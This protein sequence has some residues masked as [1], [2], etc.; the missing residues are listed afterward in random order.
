VSR[1]AVHIVNTTRIDNVFPQCRNECIAG[2]ETGH[3]PDLAR[4]SELEVVEMRS[5]IRR[6]LAVL[7]VPVLA[8][9]GVTMVWTGVASAHHVD[10]INVSCDY[11]TVNFK[12]FPSAGVNVHIAAAIEGHGDLA[13]DVL[14]HDEMSAQLDITSATSALAGA[15]AEVDVDVTWTFEG[16]QHV[17]DTFTVTCGSATTTTV[18]HCGCGSTTT[19]EAGVTTTTTAEASTTTTTLSGAGETTTTVKRG[20]GP[21]PTTE[22]DVSGSGGTTPSGTTPVSGALRETSGGAI[23]PT[24][25]TRDASGPSGI[26]PFTGGAV[27]PLLGV[28]LVLLAL[29]FVAVMHSRTRRGLTKS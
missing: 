28:A 8:L 5:A 27:L 14:V 15:T 22:V 25:A 12:D 21:T 13:T 2:N 6:L 4:G 9:L 1:S 26:L 24:G 7:S 23:L 19:T 20:H 10:G 18:H 3:A 16:D 17:N 11:V 29:G